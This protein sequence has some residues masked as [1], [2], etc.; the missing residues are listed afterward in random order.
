MPPPSQQE[1]ARSTALRSGQ[2]QGR[3][4]ALTVNDCFGVF[5]SAERRVTFLIQ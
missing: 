5:F 2:G 1:L 4:V 3:L